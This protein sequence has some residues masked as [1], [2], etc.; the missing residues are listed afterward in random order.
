MASKRD[1]LNVTHH[2]QY[3]LPAGAWQHYQEWHG[4]IMLHWKT[5]TDVLSKH[6]PDGLVLDNYNGSAYV[7]L[8]AFSVCKLRP[9]LLP[10]LPLLS[11]FHEVNLRTYVIR[12][13]KPGI[14]FLSLEAQKLF[15]ALFAR[16]MTG[17]PYKKSVIKRDGNHYLA[18]GMETALEVS[19]TKKGL[20]DKDDL[21]YWLTERHC[22]YEK[23]ANELYRLDIHHKPWKLEHVDLDIKKL[24]YPYCE[25]EPIRTHYSDKIRVLLWGKEFL[26]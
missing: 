1:I 20:L 2:R 19:Y 3:P 9:R 18:Q 8:V 6:I 4:S 12:D 23:Q 7:S 14:Y 16:L 15:P 21:D 24:H 5:D 26:F 22:L 10:P 11:N 25:G 17:L 13:R